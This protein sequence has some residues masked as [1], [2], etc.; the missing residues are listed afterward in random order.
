MKVKSESEVAQLCLTLCDPMDCSLPGSSVHGIL[1]A[2]ILQ[3][4]AISSPGIYLTQGL[5]SD[6][7]C[8]QTL[9]PSEPEGNPEN[10]GTVTERREHGFCSGGNGRSQLLQALSVSLEERGFQDFSRLWSSEQGE[11]LNLRALECPCWVFG[12]S[13]C[14]EAY[15]AGSALKRQEWE[16]EGCGGGRIGK[17]EMLQ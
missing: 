6:P 2:R 4:V 1:Q 12:S 3:W 8:R 11:L 7:H 17:G 16:R 13:A 15:C 14:D 5:N 9:L 10:Q